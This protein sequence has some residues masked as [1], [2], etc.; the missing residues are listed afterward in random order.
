MKC[1]YETVKEKVQDDDLGEYRT[2]GI[3]VM[4]EIASVSDVS[5][6]KAFVDELCRRFNACEL[7]PLNLIDMIDKSN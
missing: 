2:Y 6:D 7:S 1:R 4:V 5:L 3:R